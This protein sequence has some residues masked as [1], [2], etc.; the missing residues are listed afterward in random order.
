MAITALNIRDSR[1]CVAVPNPSVPDAMNSVDGDRD[2]HRNR[3]DAAFLAT[4]SPAV[5]KWWTSVH[6]R[7]VRPLNLMSTSK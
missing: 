1:N 6:G 4:T 7:N 5:E 3:D 2:N